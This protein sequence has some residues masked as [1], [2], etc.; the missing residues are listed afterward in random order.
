MKVNCSRLIG[1]AAIFL[2]MG[3]TAFAQLNGCPSQALKPCSFEPGNGLCNNEFPAAYNAAARFDVNCKWDLFLSVSFLYWQ[4]SQEGMDL[5]YV[6]EGIEDHLV[7]PSGSVQIQ[8][9]EY[10]PGFK[11]ALGMDFDYDN[12][13]GA[14]EYTWLHQQ[15]HMSKSAPSGFV[16]QM[17]NWYDFDYA[18]SFS[19][20]WRA[21][22]D[23]LD[24]TMSRPFY[25]SRNITITPFGGMRAAWIRQNMH[26][27]LLY[28]PESE[29]PWVSHNLSHAWSL[30]PRG[31]LQ[32]HCLLGAG[33]RME[34]DCSGSVLFT[35][36]T[37]VAHEEVTPSSLVYA[38]QYCDYNTLRPMADMSIGLGWGSYFDH[39]NYHFDLLATYDFNVMWGQ[40][41]MRSIVDTHNLG[42]A[43]EAGALYL[44]GLTVSARFDF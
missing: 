14:L 8:K 36:Y 39:Q 26:I 42:S 38:L 2:A 1:S 33:F 34:G 6:T 23:I 41:M 12:W 37:K 11:V 18:T 29:L 16:W 30:G 44:Q 24:A 32:A 40:N 43:F 17:T 19:S 7:V 3:S 5:A 28:T 27:S 21:H 13:V 15:T 9:F 31:G 4:S 22:I 20:N 35:R 25:Q 10:K